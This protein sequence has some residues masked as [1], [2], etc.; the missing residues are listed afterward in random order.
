M[1]AERA[2]RG[3]VPDAVESSVQNDKCRVHDGVF[4]RDIG[5]SIDLTY[6][7][8]IYRYHCVA[9]IMLYSVYGE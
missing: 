2:N 6:H 9:K 7:I 4:C 1:G 5:Y 8:C 3:I